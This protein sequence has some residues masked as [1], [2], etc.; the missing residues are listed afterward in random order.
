MGLPSSPCWLTSNHSCRPSCSVGLL[1]VVAKYCMPS[2]RQVQDVFCFSVS[3]YQAGWCWH[4]SSWALAADTMTQPS[5]S[6][7]RRTIYVRERSK[8]VSPEPPKKM[9]TVREVYQQLQLGPILAYWVNSTGFVYGRS[10]PWY[11]LHEKFFGA[12]STHSYLEVGE[13]EHIWL[14]PSPMVGCSGKEMVP[15]SW[16]AQ[17]GS[18]GYIYHPSGRQQCHT[19]GHSHLTHLL[20]TLQTYLSLQSASATYRHLAE[21]QK[22]EVTVSKG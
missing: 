18:F 5:V 2:S 1:S 16:Q 13:G 17:L 4:C 8:I 20:W 15:G 22:A 11:L 12:L 21:K 6:A 9:R 3:P 10:Y 7:P 19:T 14:W